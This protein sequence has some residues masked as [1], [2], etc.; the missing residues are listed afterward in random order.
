MRSNNR[1]FTKHPRRPFDDL[2]IQGFLASATARI[3]FRV[4]KGAGTV[5]QLTPGHYGRTIEVH[6]RDVAVCEVGFAPLL[7]CEATEG[8]LRRPI[9]ALDRYGVKRV[10]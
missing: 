6:L 9:N 5:G 8:L 1:K 7:P 4:N 2:C 10:W 3:D